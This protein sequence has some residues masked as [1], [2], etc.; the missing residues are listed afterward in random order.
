MLLRAVLALVAAPLIQ[1]DPGE[2]WV[3]TNTPFRARFRDLRIGGMT[4]QPEAIAWTLTGVV[5]AALVIHGFGMKATGRM[6]GGADFETIR[7]WD[8]DHPE[9]SIGTYD[10]TDEEKA[11]A[12]KENSGNLTQKE[13][14]YDTIG[15]RPDMKKTIRK[16]VRSK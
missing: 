3:E 2:N 16:E 8:K 9:N 14:L 5:A 6:D 13:R 11:Q 10:L 4:I 12:C 7:K 15:V 1:N